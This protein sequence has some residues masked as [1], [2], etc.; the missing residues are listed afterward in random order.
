MNNT[1]DTSRLYKQCQVINPISI[2]HDTR[3]ESNICTRGS[4]RIDYILCTS[5]IYKFVIKCGILPFCSIVTS[6][7]RGIYIYMDVDIIQY[8]RNPFI[9][10]N[11][12]HNR[13]LSSAHSN[14]CT[15]IKGS[16]Q[17]H[18]F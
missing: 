6:D 2:K 14:K 3:G 18:I 10:L 13:L 4:D 1:G 7:H 9:D 11:Y 15:N 8:L 12:N 17:V 5:I 16:H